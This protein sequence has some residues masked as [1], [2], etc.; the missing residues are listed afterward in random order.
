MK[1]AVVYLLFACAVLC[2]CAQ[3]YDMR[4]IG[5]GRD[6]VYMTF[7][8]GT[9]LTV[10]EKLRIFPSLQSDELYLRKALGTVEI[11]RIVD[12]ARAQVRILEGTVLDGVCAEIVE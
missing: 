1:R 12:G 9:R 8:E 2:G 11:V 5:Q 10:G 7:P 3:S 4:F 6:E